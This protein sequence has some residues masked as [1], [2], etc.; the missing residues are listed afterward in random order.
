M[1]AIFFGSKVPSLKDDE[2]S[3]NGSAAKAVPANSRTPAAAAMV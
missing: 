2:V 1:R 3:V